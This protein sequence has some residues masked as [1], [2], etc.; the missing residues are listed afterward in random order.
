MPR[1]IFLHVGMPKCATTTVQYFL[2]QNS[3][4]L[5]D[6]GISYVKHPED[7]TTGQGN[8]AEL[9][10]LGLPKRALMSSSAANVDMTFGD[11]RVF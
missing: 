8:A 5:Q 4:W 9:A 2:D 1:T 11:S 6:A 3:A 7:R 10:S